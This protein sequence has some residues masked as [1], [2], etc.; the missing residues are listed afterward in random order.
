VEFLVAAT[1]EEVSR[2]VARFGE[3]LPAGLQAQ[4]GHAV[5]IAM[6]EIL[7]NIVEHGYGGAGG[8]SIRVLW[9]PGE[10]QLDVEVWDQ[11]R[12]IPADR[13]SAVRAEFDPT[14]LAALPESGFGLELI[15]SAFDKVE[16]EQGPPYNRLL[17][18]KK[19]S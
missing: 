9:H 11:G 12:P 16:Y 5:E 19:V 6:A 18:S 15:R 1:H 4:D 3:L 13:L 7:T 10:R 14:D 2:A 17:L 8:P